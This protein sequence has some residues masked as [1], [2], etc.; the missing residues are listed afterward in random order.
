MTEFY[1]RPKSY[2]PGP[3]Q[4]E[5]VRE[6]FRERP[7][8]FQSESHVVRVAIARLYREY[9]SREAMFS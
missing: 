7:D 2:R 3:R 4:R 9:Q 1:E 6:L 5:M 8:L